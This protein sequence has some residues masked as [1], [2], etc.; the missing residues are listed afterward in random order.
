[1][2]VLKRGLRQ[3]VLL[4]LLIYCY[5]YVCLGLETFKGKNLATSPRESNEWI[6]PFW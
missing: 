2:F 4:L 5:L 3:L 1:M 6:Y